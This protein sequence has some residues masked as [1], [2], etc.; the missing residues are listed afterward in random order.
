MK[1]VFL[2]IGVTALFGFS[3]V[4][5]ENVKFLDDPSGGEGYFP[6]CSCGPG[7]NVMKRFSEF[8]LPCSSKIQTNTLSLQKIKY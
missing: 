4:F 3:L 1:K 7:V 6:V 5:A 2:V 8:F